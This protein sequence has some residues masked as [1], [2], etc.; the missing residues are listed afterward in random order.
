MSLLRADRVANR[1][2]NTG[3]VIVGPS[4]VHGDFTI[5]GDLIV[6]G[7]AVTNS[8]Q[9][10]AAFTARD[11]TI[12]QQSILN[13]LTV[14]GVTTVGLV[15]GT[16][17]TYFGDGSGLSGI[18]TTAGG[19]RGIQVLP[20]TGPGAGVGSITIRAVDVPESGF[21][22]VAAGATNLTGGDQGR[23][24]YQINPGE[25]GYS[26]TG[27][28]GEILLS[29]GTG[30]PTWSSLAAINVAYADS[31]G[32]STD[33]YGGSGGRLVYQSG[34]DQTA[35]VPTGLTGRILMAKGSG[36]PEWLDARVGLSVSFAKFAGVSTNVTGG[37]ASV[38]HLSVGE[39]GSGIA[40]FFGPLQTVDINVSGLTTTSNLEVTGIA[41]INQLEVG[42]RGN[43][44][45]GITTILDEDNLA[46]DRADALATQQSIKKY[47]DDLVTAQDLDYAGDNGSGSIDL[48]SQVFN[49]I[50]GA[51]Q[52]YTNVSGQTITVGFTTNVTIA[53]DLTVTSNAS[54]GS[55]NVSGISTLETLGVNGVL[56]TPFANVTGVATITRLNS[57]QNEF[58]DINLTGVATARTLDVTGVTSTAN[59]RVT[60]IS[61]LNRLTV[62]GI[63]TFLNDVVIGA[64]KTV[65][66]ANLSNPNIV[67]VATAQRFE[68]DVIDGPYANVTGIATI[69]NIQSTTVNVSGVSTFS[70]NVGIASLNV[71]G[72]TTLSHLGVTGVTTTENLQVAGITTIN[73]LI[74]SGVATFTGSLDVSGNIGINSA[75]LTGL[76]TISELDVTGDAS[77][78]GNAGIGS[79]NVSGISTLSNVI[80]TG[81]AGIG[82]LN[83]TGISTLE[84]LGVTGT[85]SAGFLEVVGVSTF[86]SDVQITQDLSVTGNAG[87]GSLNVTGISTFSNITVTGNAGIGSL[88]VTGV[89]TLGVTTATSLSLNEVI[90]SGLTTTATLNVGDLAGIGATVNT[91]G[92]AV[93]AG[94]I[95][96]A[97]IDVSGGQGGSATFSDITVIG[98]AGIGSLNVTGI[99]TFSDINVTGNAGIGSLNVTGISTFSNTITT[100]NAGIG[101]LNITG[102]T[103][104]G[105]F[106]TITDSLYVSGIASVGTMITMYGN[107]GVVSA[108]SFYGDGSNLTGVVGLVSVTNIVF[109]T[110]DG[111]DNNDG[112]LVST[113][114]RTVGAALTIAEASTVVKI[115]AGAYLEN[116]PII[117]PE[118]VTLLG[119]SL[120]EVSIVPQNPDQDLIYVANGSYVENMS[121]NGA[122]NEGKAIIAF[123]PNKPS[124]VTQGPYIRN[125]TNFISNSIGMKIDGA[126]VVGDTRAMNVD[127][128]TQLNQGGIGVSISNEGYA[129]LVSIFT[130]Y[131]DQSIVCT[132]G[133][134]CD[135]TNSN[136]SFGTF[137]LVADGIGPTNFIGTIDEFQSA[138]QNT[139]PINISAETVSVQNA[140]YDA[141]TGLTT[142]TTQKAHGYSKGMSVNLAGLGFTCPPYP[143]TFSSGVTDAI[144]NTGVS[145]RFSATA[146]TSY[147]PATGLLVLNIGSGH[148]QTADSE[149]TA[150]TG[151]AYNPSTGIL[152]VVTTGVHGMT[153]GDY[154]KIVEGSLR[155]TCAKDGNATNH[156]YPRATDPVNN[157]WKQVVVTN[158]TTFTM[159]IGKSSDTS[160]HTW[161]SAVASGI[162]RANSLIS[163]ADGGVTFTCAQDSNATNHSYPRSTDPASGKIFGVEAIDTAT[164]T[165]NI[166]KSPSG[167]THAFVSGVTDAIV[168]RTKA[169][170]YTA[171]VGTTYDGP[172][173]SLVLDVNTAHGLTAATA[174][175]AGSG[176]TYEP[177]TGLLTVVT[178]GAHGMTTG[179]LVKFD[180]QSLTFT[181]TSDGNNAQITYPRTTD[182]V[183]NK[184]KQVTVTNATTFTVFIGATTTGNYVHTWVSATAGG[185]KKAESLITLTDNS[186]SLTCTKDGN[187]VVKSYPAYTDPASCRILGVDAVTSD[188]ITINVGPAN[189]ATFPDNF[190]RIFT[191]NNAPITTYTATTGT[192]YNPSTGILTIVTTSANGLSTGDQV[193]IADNSLT[194]TCA[195]DANA[196]NHTY[197]R[198]TDPASNKFLTVTVTNSTTFTVDVGASS[199]TSLHNFVSAVANS[200]SS[201]SNEFTTYVGV[202]T[203]IHGYDSGGNTNNYVIR[204][205]DGQVVYF[206]S[207]YNTIEGVI[208]TNGGSGYT[209]SPQITF[210]DPSESWGIKATGTALITNGIVTGVQ[211]ISNGRGYT[212][213][214]T[215]SI[216]G[217]AT[218]T[219]DILP[220]Y[221]VVS[222]STPISQGIS[223]V[224]FT[225]NVPYALGVG[226]T[227]PFFKQSRVLASSQAFEYIGSGNTFPD[228]LPARGGVAIP[229]NEIVNKNGGLVIFTSTDQAGNFKIGEG[230]IINQLEGS[231]T[232]DA[233]NRSLFANITP[234]ILA[235]GGDS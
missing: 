121:F 161:V 65:Y 158:T 135:L 183:F 208:I 53:N 169:A 10:G 232:G 125:C 131:N 85:A 138:N 26:A 75:V 100:G 61:T 106:T 83:V 116:N 114:K 14:T 120:R 129:Q 141:S 204:P 170:S 63:T 16:S 187:T 4:T 137:G 70:D 122:L 152:T 113:A 225:D 223:T 68:F 92:G 195:T 198:T 160:L 174:L 55:L 216:A 217:A 90:V 139:F 9:I 154:V 159:N 47:V 172:T 77:V 153:T 171:V 48:D 222:S 31:A 40:T 178:T 147:D 118:Q 86:S 7:I 19:T 163:I 140:L 35:F 207:I 188:T 37:I 82:S 190:G 203:I 235:L 212:G 180:K 133:G 88:N 50:G 107:T 162:L 71:S 233:Y 56:T 191:V 209:Q 5:T 62:S 200:I 15:T 130:I 59:L 155:F 185:V 81:N 91:Y 105:G 164:I 23:I 17:A 173:G 2:N 96:A 99:S 165:L 123:N 101:S 104:L 201:G 43:T 144:T 58:T 33:L 27:N 97:G 145:N 206:D 117:L 132:S 20:N 202:S 28:T 94:I 108:T 76:T 211:M 49:I 3:P 66:N 148:G 220:T 134:Q 231:I 42:P 151:T 128:Y 142:V 215:V 176:T 6:A 78:T 156:D 84:T 214:P 74:V 124:Y 21:A 210:S 98:N 143:H 11:L 230:V 175:T 12:Q 73:D 181:C 41:T 167:G 80:V 64:G 38:T 149:F 126:N 229:E 67:G 111:N 227:V 24:P 196:T 32:I 112:Y 213:T 150:T 72:I 221:Y 87:I 51:N 29:G 219:P 22:N 54:L 1:F 194:F 93:F 186:V 79:L 8:I 52:V 218:G 157:K 127:S 36:T 226:N 89:S 13:N 60:G 45:V 44:L 18:V 30:S 168:A 57:T 192:D 95:T 224:T 69:A 119:D 228:A 199:D 115:S 25:T 110:P 193:V 197:P 102:V 177:T 103:T 205:Y 46:S 136:S 39:N 179:D 109:V 34:I 189:L 182:P 146:G 234:Y 166:G 184:W